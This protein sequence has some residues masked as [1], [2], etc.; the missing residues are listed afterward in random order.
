[1]STAVSQQRKQVGAL[2]R[3]RAMYILRK[4]NVSKAE[5]IGAYRRTNY[6]REISAQLLPATGKAMSIPYVL[7]VL[8]GLGLHSK[9]R[10]GYPKGVPMASRLRVSDQEIL[11]RLPSCSEGQIG[12][13]VGLTK[14]A[15]QQRIWRRFWRPKLT[16]QQAIERHRELERG[17]NRSSS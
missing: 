8:R 2:D 16:P 3:E 13:A 11:S 9:S 1:M 14:Q 10:P 7:L 4:Y 12:E 6:L 15:V 5:F 17:R